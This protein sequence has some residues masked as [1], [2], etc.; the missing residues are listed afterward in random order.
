MQDLLGEHINTICIYNQDSDNPTSFLEAHI[1]PKWC[2]S[3]SNCCFH[4][5]CHDQHLE[6]RHHRFPLVSTFFAPD[7][8]QTLSPLTLSRN[9]GEYSLPHFTDIAWKPKE[10]IVTSIYIF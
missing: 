10:C 7:F 3:N 8:L 4:P 6:E 5:H 9:S 1:V 2:S